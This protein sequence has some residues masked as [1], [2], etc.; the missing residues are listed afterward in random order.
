MITRGMRSSISGRGYFP[1]T[2]SGYRGNRGLVSRDKSGLVYSPGSPTVS[3][4][5]PSRLY[6]V[7]A[8]PL[9]EV[10]LL[11]EHHKRVIARSFWV[12]LTKDSAGT[13]CGC[14]GFVVFE[15]EQI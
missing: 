13:V 8:A 3:G 4:T 15:P 10:G 14:G 7:Q 5:S 6:Q 11:W 2:A 12:D 1:Y 9:A